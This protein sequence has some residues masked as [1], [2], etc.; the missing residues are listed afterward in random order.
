MRILYNVGENVGVYTTDVRFPFR[1]GKV[2]RLSTKDSEER[3]VRLVTA[4]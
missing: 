2:K 1:D 3:F 4:V